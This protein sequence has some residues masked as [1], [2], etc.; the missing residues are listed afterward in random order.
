MVNY[1]NYKKIFH[2]CDVVIRIIQDDTKGTQNKIVGLSWIEDDQLE[3]ML[4]MLFVFTID[5]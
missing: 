5:V 2:L 3:L 1:H 4:A